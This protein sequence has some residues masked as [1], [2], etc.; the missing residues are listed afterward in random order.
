[1]MTRIEKATTKEGRNGQDLKVM[2][3][4]VSIYIGMLLSEPLIYKIWDR[5]FVSRPYIVATVEVGLVPGKAD[6]MVLYD[7]DA[8]QETDATW[9]ASVLG[10]Q[11]EQIATRRGQGAYS[12]AEDEPR[13]WSW[14]AFF[15]NEY[16]APSPEIPAE[17]FRV[18]VR[19]LATARDSGEMDESPL[20]CSQIFDPTAPEY[21]KL[22]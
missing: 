9:I 12:D 14:D 8:G 16:G 7:A 17:P 13:L 20:Y 5:Y 21:L 19:Y 15:K 2:L 18:C 1:M 4:G 6:P 11:L 10:L 22:P 3:I